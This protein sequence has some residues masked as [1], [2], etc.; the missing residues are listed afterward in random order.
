MPVKNIEPMFSIV[1]PCLNE[2]HYIINLLAALECQDFGSDF[3][4]VIVVDNN[5]TDNTVQAIWD[6]SFSSNLSLKLVHEY[7]PG[8]SIARNSGAKMTRGDVIIF[9][10]ADN[11]VKSDFLKKLSLYISNKKC[12]AGSIRTLPD[13]FSI[14]GWFVFIIL[15][16]IK[17]VLP[18]PF[19][20]SFVERAVFSSSGGFDETVVLGE[21]IVFLQNVKRIVKNNNG[22]FGHFS[23]AIKCSLR[24]F[25]KLGY[26]KILLPWFIAYLGNHSQKYN[27]MVDVNENKI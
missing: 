11:L 2:E 19:G 16:I 22:C 13:C 18:R 6:Y 12:S 15:E 20:K 8:V 23:P 17:I 25:N 9:L 10:D 5:C 14:K 4:E 3:F 1:V 26:I 24:R 21:N 27:T 7:T